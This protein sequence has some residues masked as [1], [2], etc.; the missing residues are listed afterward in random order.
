[1]QIMSVCRLC[2]LVAFALSPS[3]AAVYSGRVLEDHSGSPLS[4]V[5]IRISRP[6]LAGV[7][8]E[9]ETDSQGR[10]HT[11]D[12][13]PADYQF[14]FSRV[15]YSSL[16]VQARPDLLLHLIHYG[17]ISGRVLDSNGHPVPFAIMAAIT[18]TAQTAGE[19]RDGEYRIFGLL[20]GRYR[21][22]ILTLGREVRS[23]TLFY[24]N[25][26]QPREFVVAGGEEYTAD[27]LLTDTSTYT[28]SG[29]TEDSV[30]MVDLV[31]AE[32]PELRVAHTV[33]KQDGSFQFD[34]IAP[35]N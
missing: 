18:E 16:T 12:L 9:A 27:F 30:R 17:A 4:R 22:A 25:N 15:N 2:L 34:H 6:D 10:Y 13:P 32:H 1:M 28:V 33:A 26:S 5:E 35:G 24:P 3:T 11:P 8:A 21:L 14:H 19:T 23:G 7:V 31:S 20:P 29:Q